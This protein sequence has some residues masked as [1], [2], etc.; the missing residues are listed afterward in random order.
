MRHNPPKVTSEL[1]GAELVLRVNGLLHL[2]VKRNEITAVQSWIG[3]HGEFCI[4]F[5]MRHGEDVLLEYTARP[6][7]EAVLRQLDGMAIL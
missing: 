5:T 2:R 7:W 3:T 4:E 6:I 1:T